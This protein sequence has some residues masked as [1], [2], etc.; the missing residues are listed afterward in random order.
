MNGAGLGR[1]LAR[2][3][4]PVGLDSA[5]PQIVH[6]PFA[7]LEIPSSD[8][9]SGRGRGRRLL[10]GFAQNDWTPASASAIASDSVVKDEQTDKKVNTDHPHSSSLLFF[11]YRV[12]F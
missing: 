3:S 8:A 4:G 5:L 6:V 1:G 9:L 11:L 2:W 12:F 7:S 10:S